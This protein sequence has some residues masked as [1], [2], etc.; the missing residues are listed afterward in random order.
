MMAGHGLGH[1][2]GT[3]DK[4]ESIP[5]FRT[6]IDKK[7]FL[8]ILDLIGVSIIGQTTEIV[9]V[10]KKI[11]AL[12]DVTATVESIPLICSSI[13]S[14]KIAEGVENLVLDVK[15]GTG[16]FMK[17]YANAT[18]LSEKMINI[19][20]KFNVNT[21]VVISDMDAPLGNCTGNSLEIKQAIE[22][23]KGNLKNDLYELSIFLSALM[24]YNVKKTI[25]LQEAKILAQ[26]QIESGAALE[27]FKR[28]VQCESYRRSTTISA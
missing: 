22:I 19:G 25:T 11:Y 4:L 28:M 15:V 6:N 13:M 26:K 17:T 21:S 7:E 10:D 12:R 3:L 24:I 5:G 27:K 20:K 8:N 9:P 16:S 23:L 14:K 2:D 18:R 1:T